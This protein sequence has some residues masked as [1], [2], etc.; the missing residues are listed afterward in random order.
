[1]D[2]WITEFE[3]FLETL[4]DAPKAISSDFAMQVDM[5]RGMVEST[6]NRRSV[7]EVT[8][9]RIDE[10]RS[11]CLARKFEDPRYLGLGLATELLFLVDYGT[12]GLA[13]QRT[14]ELSDLF[15]SADF[16][17]NFSWLSNHMSHLSL[18]KG[19]LTSAI[20][21]A[22]ACLDRVRDLGETRKTLVR[23]HSHAILGQ[24]Y[25]EQNKIDLA[26]EH[27]ARV[28]RHP[29]YSLITILVASVCGTA[30]IRAARGEM[31]QA[32]AG[33]EEAYK[34]A[35]H[36]GIPHLKVITAAT[37][38][39]FLLMAGN[40]DAC[41]DWISR[42]DLESVLKRSQLWF[43][44]PWLE[45]EALIRLFT[46]LAIKQ[47]HLDRAHDLAHEFAVR[48]RESGRKLMAARAELL[49]MDVELKHNRRLAAQQALTRA[50]EDTEGSGA[51]RL[52]LDMSLAGIS[53]LKA[54]QR[55]KEQSHSKRLA[56]LLS[57]IESSS[58]TEKPSG[59]SVSPRE[60]EVL[61]ALSNG[62]PPKIIAR[63]LDL[64]YETVRHH[65]K[66]IYAKLD[67]HSRDQAVNEA[68]RRR[69]IS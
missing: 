36:E 19:D 31:E 25:L 68:L 54:M 33:L 14:N 65:L 55:K 20:D 56:E 35:S 40:E 49:L 22:H 21:N 42:E 15:T 63:N 12:L 13:E 6:E 27:L 44:R 43:T 17:P 58:D 28:P 32:I 57:T 3:H 62:Q 10:I 45:T 69:I 50:L 1:M 11:R 26:L 16:A 39:E 9:K 47:G 5:I 34:F 24:C 29:R 23:Q 60:K 8:Q 52:F 2:D 30:R 59:E 66:N 46:L 61:I 4:G 38:A 41:L 67:V 64:S 48:A 18:A 7:V 53:L 37:V 51:V